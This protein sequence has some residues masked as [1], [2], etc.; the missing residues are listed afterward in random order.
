MSSESK[1]TESKSPAPTEGS[2]PGGSKLPIILAIVN[3]VITLGMVAIL[4]MSFQKQKQ[5]ATVEDIVAQAGAEG[6]KS[7]KHGEHGAEKPAGGEHGGGA[8]AHGE[9]GAEAGHGAEGGHEGG[10]GGG[11][12]SG[13][14]AEEKAKE[15]YGRI[16]TLEQFTVNLSTTGSGSS[17]GNVKFARVNISLEIPTEDLETEVNAK[18]PQVR[19]AVIDLFN[20]KRPSDLSTVDGREYL[21]EEIKTAI[22]GFLEK[23]KIKGVFFTS[24]ALA[25]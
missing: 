3:T 23:G 19:N 5:Q 4:F 20:S 25:G 18:I 6:E 1:E 9:H 14:S 12:E 21:K 17:G 10:H 24:F 2:S 16:V 13:K 15:A 11:H 8:E 7:E 22:D